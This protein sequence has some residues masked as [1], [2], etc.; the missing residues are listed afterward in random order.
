MN[1]EDRATTVEGPY[2]AFDDDTADDFA[3]DGEEVSVGRTA[4]NALHLSDPEVSRRHARFLRNGDTVTLEDL[5]SSNGT[6]VNGTQ[7]TGEAVL[8]DG[9]RLAFAGVTATF[10]AGAQQQPEPTA[11]PRP[12][13]PLAAL[14]GMGLPPV[15][16]EAEETSLGRAIDNDM[17]L[18]DAAVSAHH[19]VIRRRGQDFLL[20]DLG[21]SNGTHLN[22]EQITGSPV[23]RP[24]D[25]IRIGDTVVF[26]RR[27]A[28]Y[29][30]GG[31]L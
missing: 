18:E 11:E 28:P 13:L 1:V 25:E 31:R 12:M 16:L 8:Q 9:D 30:R 27:L 20:A 3:I 17:V 21:S 14:E 26:F 19:A 15:L 24:G 2:L 29:R 4:E 22:G 7:I 5:G 10:H 23:L 6:F